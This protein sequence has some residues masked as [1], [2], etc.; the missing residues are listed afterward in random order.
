MRQGSWRGTS[1][2]KNIK[3]PPRISERILPDREFRRNSQQFLRAVIHVDSISI[4]NSIACVCYC[5]QVQHILVISYGGECISRSKL[6]FAGCV[7]Y[8][9]SIARA[10]HGMV[11][12]VYDLQR[13]DLMTDIPYTVPL[14]IG[15]TDTPS[16]DFQRW[17]SRE[18]GGRAY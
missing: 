14:K 12:G 1:T 10:R 5:Y 18:R 8:K 13:S 2:K 11:V 3:I 7:R 9:T 4:N 15:N 6:V 16:D 17:V